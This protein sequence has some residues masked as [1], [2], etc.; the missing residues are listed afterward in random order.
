MAW[1]DLHD[2]R[3]RNVVTTRVRKPEHGPKV[4]RTALRKRFLPAA[5]QQNLPFVGTVIGVS[6]NFITFG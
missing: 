2:I 6:D 4:I 5:T 3:W 1:V